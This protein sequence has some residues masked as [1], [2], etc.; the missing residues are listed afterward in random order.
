MCCGRKSGSR[1]K[2][3]GK[4]IKSKKVQAQTVDINDEQYSENQER[5]LLLPDD[6]SKGK[7]GTLDSTK[8]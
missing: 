3:R 7:E 2:G 6:E 5:L 1:R 8:I 4:L